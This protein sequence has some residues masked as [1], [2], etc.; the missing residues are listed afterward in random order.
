MALALMGNGFLYGDVLDM[1]PD[2]MNDW[3]DSAAELKRII[4]EQTGA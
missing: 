4:K 1:T 3:M 2:E